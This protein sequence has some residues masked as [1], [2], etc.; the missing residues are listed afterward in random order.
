MLRLGEIESGAERSSGEAMTDQCSVRR[1]ASGMLRGTAGRTGGQPRQLGAG[2]A[3]CDTSVSSEGGRMRGQ[4]SGY[5]WVGPP[6][7]V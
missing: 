4:R 1:G 7:A 6:G 5:G 3:R 2:S